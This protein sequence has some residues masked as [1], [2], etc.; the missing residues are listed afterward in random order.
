MGLIEQMKQM[1]N[2][3]LFFLA[4]IL[5]TSCGSDDPDENKETCTAQSGPVSGT[6]LDR[7]F[8]L[9]ATRALD[10]DEEEMEY[11]IQMFGV[12]DNEIGDVCTLSTLN[13]NGSQITFFVGAQPE[14]FDFGGTRIVTLFHS[15][16]MEFM[17]TTNG[18]YEVSA[19]TASTIQGTLTLRDDAD[20]I[21]VSGSW[22]AE[23]CD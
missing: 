8:E 22:V 14:Q 10:F 5:M 17:T 20:E 18:C 19:V 3:T 6:I 15:A 13:L 4:I 7:N 21:L 9:Q 2:L 11:Q 23:R 16:T 12:E 1:K